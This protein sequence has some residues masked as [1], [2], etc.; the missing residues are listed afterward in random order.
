MK[1]GKTIW[2]SNGKEIILHLNPPNTKEP[3]K[4]TNPIYKK[5][6]LVKG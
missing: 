4:Y 6:K 5:R 3:K 2:T 1:N